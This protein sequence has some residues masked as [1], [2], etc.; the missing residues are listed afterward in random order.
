MVKVQWDGSVVEKWCEAHKKEASHFILCNTC[1]DNIAFGDLDAD[2]KL[3][4]GNGEPQD[5]YLA[6]LEED[7]DGTCYLCKLS[8]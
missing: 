7:I 4:P 8:D 3:I 2:N 6:V 5:K 1:W